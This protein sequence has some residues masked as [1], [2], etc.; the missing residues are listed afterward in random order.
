MTKQ[1]EINC[2][3]TV[4]PI[5]VEV[6]NSHPDTTSGEVM[7]SFDL[8]Q[9]EVVERRRIYRDMKEKS[10]EEILVGNHINDRRPTDK[11][12]KTFNAKLV[13]MTLE[14]RDQ[15][16]ELIKD[17]KDVVEINTGGEML[18]QS[19]IEAIEEADELQNS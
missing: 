10:Y 8:S 6:D 16:I 18:E 4:E 1:T 14:V 19:C 3:A 5:Q 7:V 17:F 13:T 12:S 15:L 2:N 9:F 11:V